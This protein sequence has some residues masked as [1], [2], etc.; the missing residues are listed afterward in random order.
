MA[1]AAEEEDGSGPLVDWLRARGGTVVG[2][3]VGPVP[4]AGRRGV[5]A[6]RALPQHHVL[7][8]VPA[9]LALTAASSAAAAELERFSLGLD[10]AGSPR[11]AR[12]ALVL[13]VLAEEAAGTSS[14]W[15][16]YLAALPG[17]ASGALRCPEL[18][19]RAD[20]ALLRGTSVLEDLVEPVDD[21]VELPCM[22]RE[23]WENVAAPFVAA[24]PR[25]GLRAG[26][27]GFRAYLRAVALVSG[28][29][30]SLGEGGA[31]Q[32]MVPFWVSSVSRRRRGRQEPPGD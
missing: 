32:A 27:R 19:S 14:T 29:S 23:H 12:E 5:V 22:T 20:R 21:E 9:A 25:L 11:L 17:L 8:A 28:Y 16:G 2:A 18:W 24:F 31:I 4:G 10:S 13:A 3:R 15:H 26:K 7:C 6:T 30:F 1:G